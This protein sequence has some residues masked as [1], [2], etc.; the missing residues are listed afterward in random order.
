VE[1]QH[2]QQKQIEG[3][4]PGNQGEKKQEQRASQ[5]D[6]ET[7]SCKGQ[8]AVRERYGNHV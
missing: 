2:G 3:K 7:E 5:K 1:E 4:A 6:Q 8:A